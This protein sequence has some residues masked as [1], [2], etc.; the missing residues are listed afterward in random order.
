LL[1]FAFQAA[2]LGQHSLGIRDTNASAETW[3]RLQRLEAI[4]RRLHDPHCHLS[5]GELALHWGFGDQAQFT[6]SFRQ[7]FG[8]TA[9]EVRAGLSA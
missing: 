2:R 3:I 6:R 8:C 4:N 1:H 5:I 7:H 9:S